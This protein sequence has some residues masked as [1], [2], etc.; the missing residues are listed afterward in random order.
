MKLETR[1]LIVPKINDCAVSLEYVFDKLCDAATGVSVLRWGIVGASAEAVNVEYAVAESCPLSLTALQGAIDVSCSDGDT[2][3]FVIPTGVG[4]SIGGFIGDASP[5]ARVINSISDRFITHPNVV[6]AATLYGG[7]ASTIYVD[8]FTLDRFLLG[9][10]ALRLCTRSHRIGV[11]V[12]LLPEADADVTLHAIEA[13]RTVFGIDISAVWLSPE[14]LQVLTHRTEGGHYVGHVANPDVIAQGAESL[15]R[16]GAEVIAAV[17]SIG[18]ITEEQVHTHYSG[19]GVNPVGAAEALIS[20]FITART[21]LP[22]AHAPAFGTVLGKSGGIAHP[23]VSAELLSRSGL[24]SVLLGLSKAAEPTATTTEGSIRSIT[25]IVVPHDC[26]GGV[27]ALAAI[28]RV[29]PFIAVRENRCSVGLQCSA[30]SGELRST[31]VENYRDAIAYI[32]AMRAGISYQALFST[33][34]PLQVVHER[35]AKS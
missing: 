13:A 3:V 8:G 7:T 22:A 35:L 17:T 31:I 1:Q 15:K 23:R 2:V 25:V 26:A 28:R 30:L 29:V 10:T 27:P 19:T 18:G 5:I 16:S 11:L 6:N 32:A 24:S 9:L 14:K 12:D 33:T 21:G 34:P 4:A 20:R